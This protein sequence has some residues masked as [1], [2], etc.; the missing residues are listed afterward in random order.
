MLFRSPRP[1]RRA[2]ARVLRSVLSPD[3]YARLR[4][5]ASRRPRLT[6]TVG[7]RAAAIALYREEIAEL[8]DMTGR[9]LSHWA[10]ARFAYTDVRGGRDA[11]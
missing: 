1:L 3:R 2:G 4:A 11:R 7:E 8:A 9:D 5:W 6:P 10:D